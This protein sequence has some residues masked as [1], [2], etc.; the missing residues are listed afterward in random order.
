MAGSPI[1]VY[2]ESADYLTELI[3]RANPGLE[4]VSLK[5]PVALRS[6]L[7]DIEILF[8]PSPPRDGWA[9]ANRLRLIQLLGSGVDSLLPS[10][11]LPH[12]VE[13][14]GVRGMFAADVAEHA[15]AMMLSHS[16]RLAQLFDAQRARQFDSTPRPTLAGRQL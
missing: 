12:R 13:V 14:A 9:G 5:T 15:L 11:D 10:P 7:A 16:R 4:V 1:H 6:S 2:H 8:A 3:H